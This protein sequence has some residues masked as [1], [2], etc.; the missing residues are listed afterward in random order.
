ML[1]GLLLAGGGIDSSVCMGIAA[2]QRIQCR[3]L[4]IDYG[5]RAAEREWSAVKAMAVFYGHE[6]LQ[7]T[8]TGQRK[9]HL[10][11]EYIG[12]NCALVHLALMQMHP[13][14]TRI[15]I[16]IHAG[17]NFYDCSQRFYS[18]CSVLVTEETDSRVSL[19][20]PLLNFT[21]KEI[22]ELARRLR[23]PFER[24]YSCQAGMADPCGT[25]LSC[26]DREATGC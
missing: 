17:T 4:H 8:L 21:K 26:R 24:T 15:Y 13:D 3:A 11:G 2:E 9:K 10:P 7:I 5:Q 23:L 22:V 12:R 1:H 14:E 18:L 25:C 20:A 19:V 6:P 16:G